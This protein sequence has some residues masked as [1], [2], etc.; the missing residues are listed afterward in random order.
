MRKCKA[1][2]FIC[3]IVLIGLL[4]QNHSIYASEKEV[5]F[6]VI[7]IDRDFTYT[8]KE[9]DFSKTAW[10][11]DEN[12]NNLVKD[13][14]YTIECYNNINAGEGTMVVTGIGAYTGE[15]TLKFKINKAE[16]K[17]VNIEKIPVQEFTSAEISPELKMQYIYNYLE[18]DVDYKVSFTDNIECGI[19]GVEITGIG[20]YEGTINKTFRIINP[21]DK[22]K[23]SEVSAYNISQIYTG[24][25]I[26]LDFITVKNIYGDILVKD[27]DYIVE[28]TNNIN[29]GEASFSVRGIRDYTG[30]IDNKFEI[31]PFKLESSNIENIPNQKYTGNEI[32]PK[33]KVSYGSMVLSEGIDY[34]VEYFDNISVG[35][36]KIQ[37]TGMGN[38]TG[39]ITKNFNIKSSDADKKAKQTIKAENIT[40][41]FSKKSFN[42][43]VT[44][45]DG[46]KLKYVSSNKK[47]VT[48]D[49]NGIIS[50]KGAGKSV[51]KIVALETEKYKKAEKEIV[52]S[53]LPKSPEFSLSSVENKGIK[54]RWAKGSG[55]GEN[56]FLCKYYIKYS[57]N[58][59]FKSSKTIAVKGNDSSTVI[60]ELKA[61]KVYYVKM[62]TFSTELKKY[63]GW[64]KYK[65]IEI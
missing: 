55:I 39:S 40:K 29:V 4:A 19:A 64:T 38:Y 47:V 6:D 20:N 9:V 59:S 32:C 52:V 33:L 18:K 1:G 34:S 54:V 14:D 36:A 15:R 27:R 43:K 65:K 53:I 22:N 3:I 41:T 31:I 30:T 50:I 57:L 26:Y 12:G 51:I 45:K 23:I 42:L 10:V 49:G 37:L 25:P 7:Y 5:L 8:G 2:I 35:I 60:K 28:Y 46:A 44:I 63:S 56:K 61:G 17:N 16:L 62:R 58:K 13:V 48:V 21:N 11:V 24:E